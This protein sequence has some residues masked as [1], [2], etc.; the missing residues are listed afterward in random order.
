MSNNL[1][2]T[3]TIEFI[4]VGDISLDH[5]NP[6]LPKSIQKGSEKSI[7]N[8]MLTNGSL[9]ELMVSIT[10]N[11]YFE[12]EPILVIPDTLKK[13]KFI[14]IEG[15]RR[16]S[17]IKILNN[18]TLVNKKENSI[19]E[20]ITEAKNKI[21]NELPSLVFEKESDILDYLGYRHITGVKQWSPLAKARYLDKLYKARKSVKDIDEKYKIIANIIGSKGYNTK[22]MHTTYRVFEKAEANNFFGIQ[23]ISEESIEFSNLN[24]ALTKFS[25]IS[26]F[27]KIDFDKK[28]PISSI[29]EKNVKEIFTWLFYRHPETHKTRLGEVRNLPKLNAILNPNNKIARNAFLNGDSIEKSFFLTDEP[30][31]LF[32]NS[33]NDAYQ[34]LQIAQELFYSLDNPKQE[35]A[36]LLKMINAFSF[37]FYTSLTNKLNPTVKKI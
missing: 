4:K 14:V 37:D 2:S 6:R 19:S 15:N 24:D 30:N 17:A 29:D 34:K 21:P 9:L 11:G 22:R 3:K 1:K 31:I 36:E 16:L 10:E 35:D 33:L 7:L 12:G 23:G 20:I 32:S 26:A 27:A 13:G 8:W 5:S 28:D 25:H 18:P